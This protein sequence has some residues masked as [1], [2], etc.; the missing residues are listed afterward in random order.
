LRIVTT[1]LE[2]YSAIQRAAQ[3]EALRGIC[4]A[5]WRQAVAP[6]A[7]AE[8][9]PPFAVLPRGAGCVLCGDFN[10]PAGAPEHAPLARPGDAPALQDAWRLVH[11]TVPRAPTFGVHDRRYISEPACYDFCF[12]SANIAERVRAIAVDGGCTASDHQPVLLELLG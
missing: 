8:T 9:D 3:V 5:G 12:V 11:G 1:H 4:D 2:Y 7:N 6:P 10:S